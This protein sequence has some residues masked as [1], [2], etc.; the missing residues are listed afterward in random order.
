[1]AF[2]RV[3]HDVLCMKLTSQGVPIYIVRILFFWLCTQHFYVKWGSH[4]SASFRVSNGVHRG[5]L[6]SPILFNVYMY[7]LCVRLNSCRI[8]C[9]FSDNKLNHLMYA[10]DIALIAP[11]VKG[12]DQL[13]NIHLSHLW[14]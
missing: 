3:N 11:S 8:G 2:D 7:D 13:M 12:L 6:L 1:M 4:C 5:G 9:C 14:P 10:D